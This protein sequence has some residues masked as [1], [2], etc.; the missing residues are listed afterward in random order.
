MKSEKGGGGGD[1][2]FCGNRAQSIGHKCVTEGGEVLKIVQICVTSFMNAPEG[3]ICKRHQANL[4][5]FD[6]FPL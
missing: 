3:I 5:M 4:G 2:A 6:P 1:K